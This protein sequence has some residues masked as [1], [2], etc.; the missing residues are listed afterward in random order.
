VPGPNISVVIPTHGGPFLTVSVESVR[1]QTT[2][3]WE[4]V[5]V[6]DGST[7]G[8]AE[9]A[10]GLAAEDARIRV[11][12]NRR[13][14]GIA[15]ARNRGLAS[16]SPSSEYVA[17]LDHDDAW[18]AKTLETLRGELI[19]RPTASAAHGTA[20]EID[21]SGKPLSFPRELALRRMGIV[22]GRLVEW[23]KERSTEFAN[24]AYEDCIVSMGSGLIRR[25]DLVALRGFDLR[26][27]PA[28]DYDLWIR[29]ARRGEIGF[30]DSVVLAY[31]IH[32]GQTSSRPPPRRG[33]GTPYVRYKTITSSDNTSEQRHLAIA[34]FRLRQKRL[35]RQRWSDLRTDWRTGD[36]REMPRHL[37]DGVARVA[38]YARGRP[39]AWHR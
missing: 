1:A 37:L 32:D 38:A 30:V 34:G 2:G 7:D 3:D 12:T 31:R 10:S 29:L 11:V 17:F 14:T 8:T 19:R 16:I 25:G 18:M 26:A 35:F 15:A 9:V 4:I 22:G 13:N 20:F 27:E 36:Y 28:D 33:R 5:I 24:L 6:D 21:A 23:P 39:W